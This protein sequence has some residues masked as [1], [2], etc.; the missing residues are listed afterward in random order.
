MNRCSSYFAP[1]TAVSMCYPWSL[2]LNELI[3]FRR[4]QLYLSTYLYIF[5]LFISLLFIYKKKVIVFLVLDI[6]SVFA[7]RQPDDFLRLPHSTSFYWNVGLKQ[8]KAYSLFS[9]YRG[10]QNVVQ[11]SCSFSTRPN[12]ISRS[13]KGVPL[14]SVTCFWAYG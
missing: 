7:G 8:W 13:S 11:S 14:I 4:N 2:T 5:Y 1:T 3:V 6:T 9:M 10:Q 12:T